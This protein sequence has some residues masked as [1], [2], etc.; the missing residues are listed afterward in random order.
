MP[1]ASGDGL[2]NASSYSV[3]PV[4]DDHVVRDNVTQ[5]MWQQAGRPEAV[6]WKTALDYC[7]TLTFAGETD[8][9]LPTR[10][11]LGS[12]VDHRRSQPAID[13]TAFPSSPSTAF[14]SSSPSTTPGEAWMV[15]FVMGYSYPDRTVL[16]RPARCVRDAVGTRQCH[17]FDVVESAGTVIDAA[18]GL[19]WQRLIDSA[20][21]SWDEAQAYC[22]SL[23]LPGDGWRLPSM[24]E[25]QTLVDDRRSEP[26]IDVASFPD[27]PPAREDYFW[28]STT[29]AGDQASVWLLGFQQGTSA[30][31]GKKVGGVTMRYLVRCVR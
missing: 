21:L 6:D 15:D 19:T 31:N 17:T 22:P 20:P 8:W 28:T 16:T 30:Y 11:E 29:M 23:G 14:W 2:P 7:A 18:T 5:L 12:L 9:R 13:L 1:N 24:K 4:G 27:T 3:I 26:A 25:L 10:I